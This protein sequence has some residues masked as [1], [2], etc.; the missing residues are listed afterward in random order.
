MDRWLADGSF[1]W[2]LV[3][4][5]AVAEFINELVLDMGDLHKT[6]SA[7]LDP[8]HSRLG[9][10]GL[11][12]WMRRRFDRHELAQLVGSGQESCQPLLDKGDVYI[13]NTNS[14]I[15]E[16]ETYA[17]MSEITYWFYVK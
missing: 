12:R 6:L 1:E 9:I 14:L 13:A 17:C 4:A 7:A 5:V 2:S 3:R 15:S 8:I 10:C 16:G 11:E